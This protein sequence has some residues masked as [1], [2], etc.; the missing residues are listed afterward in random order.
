MTIKS[1]NALSKPS[2]ALVRCKHQMWWTRRKWIPVYWPPHRDPELHPQ[3][4]KLHCHIAWN[5]LPL[6]I[7]DKL[8]FDSPSVVVVWKSNILEHRLV[9]LPIISPPVSMSYSFYKRWK[10]IFS[11]PANTPR[12]LG[13]G[14]AQP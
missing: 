14:Q 12:N 2:I 5:R 9:D 6:K 3:A 7:R 10:E 4:G 8:W 11:S 1:S 13:K